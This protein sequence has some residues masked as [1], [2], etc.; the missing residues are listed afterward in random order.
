V[1]HI[2]VNIK[3]QIAKLPLPFWL[4]FYIFLILLVVPT[5]AYLGSFGKAAPGTL[6]TTINQKS[7][8]NDPNPSYTSVFTVQFNEAIDENTFTDSDI[9]LGGTAPGQV[10]QSITEAGTFNKT[11]YEVRIQ[12]TS[13]GTITPTI[14]QELIS[15]QNGASGT[16]QASTS[17]D[18][19]VT[20]SGEWAP[21]EFVTTWKTDNPGVSGSNQI[22][23][24]TTGGGYN[25][26][27]DWGD[28]NTS[29]GL[30]GNS[31]HTYAST[32]TYTVSITGTFPRIAFNNNGDRQKILT[33]EQWGGNPWVS[34]YTAFEGATNLAIPATDAPNL[35]GVTDMGWMLKEA[36]SFNSSINHWNTQNV[37]QI[38][39]LFSGATAFNQPLDSWDVS[40]V[41]YMNAVFS[42][43]TSFNQPLDNWDVSNV[44]SSMSSMFSG[45]TAFNQPLNNWELSTSGSLT[46]ESM[47][48][49]A[50]AFNQPLDS[51]DVSNV[52]DTS[53]MFYGATA[54]NQP[55]DNWDV[56]N[57]GTLSGMFYGA[58]SF[59]Q[60]L[61]SW[62]ISNVSYLNGM[63]GDGS[64]LS[65]ANYDMTLISWN[66]Q[67]LQNNVSFGA[68]SSKYCVSATERQSII[69]NHSWTISDGGADCASTRAPQVDTNS[70]TNI[71]DVSA[72]L[73]GV[74]SPDTI[75]ARG[76]QYGTTTSYGSTATDSS[77]TIT[78]HGSSGTGDGQF[79]FAYGITTDSSG[80]VYVA[81]SQNHRIQKF[82]ADGNYLMR[83]G[84]NGSGNGQMS[85]PDDVFVDSSGNIFVADSGNHRIQKFNSSGTYMSQWG[86]NGSG[87]GQFSTP[88]S[89]TMDTNGD[90][91]VADQDNH[92]I[93]KFDSNGNYLM[94]LGTSGSG[95]GQLN[96]PHGVTV[97]ST[98]YIY[99]A[100]TFNHRIQK[101]DSSGSYV[102]KWGSA[103]SGNGQFSHPSNTAIDKDGNIYVMDFFNHRVQKFSNN[104]FYISQFGS[105]GSG[106]TQFTFPHDLEFSPNGSLY[107]Q[108]NLNWRMKKYEGLTT[109]SIT[110]LTCGT[111]YHY[112]A[113]ASNSFG[114]GYGQ[115]QTFTTS[116]CPFI[117]TWK[118]DNPGGSGS[119]QLTI[120]TI[121]GG[122]NYNVDCGNN[123]SIEHTNQT[124]SV[125]CTFGSPG[126]YQVAITGTFPRIYFAG[127]GDREKIL[128]IDQWGSNQWSSMERAFD[129]AINLTIPAADAPNLNNVTIMSYMFKDAT[130][131]NQPLNSWDMG[132]V[133]STSAM[134][135]GATS[136]NQP[137]NS[138]DVSNVTH[139][140]IMFKD[141]TSFN[142]PLNN[143]D[144]SNVVSTPGMFEGATSFN[145]PLN[146]WDV[147]S[148]EDTQSM[149]SSSNF[150][151]PL[152]NWDVSSVEDMKFL[153]YDNPVFNQPLNDW[154]TA[155]LKTTILTFGGASAFNQPLNN[156][157]MDEVVSTVGM[158]AGAISYDQSL[159]DW[160]VSSVTMMD[161]MFS[162]WGGYFPNISGLSMTNYDATITGWSAQTLQNGVT[163]D[164]GTSMYCS[165]EAQR[166]SIITNFSWT[167]NDA[168][169][170]CAFIMSVKTDNFG[171]S[172]NDS[173]AIP[174]YSGETYNYNVDCGNNGSI[175]H[176]NQTGS[177]TCTFGSPGTYQV[178]I[179]GTFPRI[180]FAGGGD[181]EK[182]LSIDQW[183]SNQWSSMER[184]F[185]GAINLTVPATNAPDLSNVL[186]MDFMFAD[187]TSLNQSLNNWDVSNVT[188]MQRMF[189]NAT[190]FNQPLNNWNVSNVV[191]IGGMFYYANSFNQSLSNWDVSNV[192]DTSWMFYGAHDFNQSL[193]SWNTGNVVTMSRMFGVASAF[194]QPLNSWNVSSVI[195]MSHMFA[196]ASLFDQPLNNWDV[197]SVENMENM[198]GW[199]LVTS[200]GGAIVHTVFNRDISSWNVSNVTNMS[201]MFLANSE[202]NQSLDNWNVSSVIDMSLMF[203][204][205]TSFNQPI[206]NWDVSNVLTMEGM[207]ANT[208][209][210]YPLNNW[211]VS[212]VTNMTGIF[213]GTINFDQSLA[214]W[215]VS[216]VVSM[217]GM[218]GNLAKTSIKMNEEYFG[219][220]FE[221]WP[222]LDKD[223]FADWML[224]T[225][226]ID[227]YNDN[228]DDYDVAFS[229]ANYDAT[230][231]GWSSQNLES[232]VRLDAVDIHYC[233]SE[234]QRQSTIT[235]LS[236]TINDAGKECPATAPTIPITPSVTEVTITSMKFNWQPPSSDGGSPIT[237]YQ[238]QYKASSSST[239]ISAPLQGPSPTTHVLTNLLSGTS[240]DLRVLATNTI[241]SSS[242]TNPITGTTMTEPILPDEPPPPDPDPPVYP[243]DNPDPDSDPETPTTDTETNTPVPGTPVYVSPT[244]GNQNNSRPKST[245]EKILSMLGF[246]QGSSMVKSIVSMAEYTPKPVAQ[247]VPYSLLSLLIAISAFYIY[248]SYLE[249]QRRKALTTLFTR[250][251][252]LLA[253][254]ATYLRITSHYI[255]TPITKMQ[256]TIELLASGITS[257]SSSTSTG[258]TKANPTNTNSS[259]TTTNPKAG[260]TISPSSNSNTANSTPTNSTNSSSTNLP[261]PVALATTTTT[262]TIPE[263]AIV[264]ANNGLKNLANHASELLTEGQSLTGQ[265]QANIHNLEKKK[266]LSFLTHPAFWLPV[267]TISTIVILLNI[268]FIQ[269][270]RYAPT[271]ITIFSQLMLGFVG[272]LALGV[273]Y[274]FYQ[275]RKEQ[276]K[277]TKQQQ[278]IETEFNL[279]QANFIAEA[280][281]KLNDDILVLE[282]VKKDIARYPKVSGFTD[283]LK[284]LKAIANQLEKLA[285]LSKN[286]PGL[287]WNTNLNQTI[288]TATQNIQPLADKQNVTITSNNLKS[289]TQVAVEEQALV[290]LIT[291]PIKNAI[292]ASQPGNQ[293][294]LTQTTNPKDKQHPIQLTITDQGQ[295]IPADQL[296]NIFTPFN[297]AHSL[298][299]F[300]DTGLGIDLYLCKV[301]TTQYNATIDITSQ[302]GE[303]T[304]VALGFSDV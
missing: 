82:D 259:S 34:M 86:T 179:T 28:G 98:G 66:Q 83:F 166:Q 107:I 190:S 154:N 115:D 10:V 64:G 37:L 278:D 248:L 198:F 227:I 294:K 163:F 285:S 216:N 256:G 252:A 51:W 197:S 274:Y 20:Y 282:G 40:N 203:A 74:T 245:K 288:A 297:S 234:I 206:N 157:D 247:A 217:Q 286:V 193:N 268:I 204:H 53:L 146:S 119:N 110:G 161:A 105:G 116:G 36:T 304:T 298:E 7:G 299:R 183:G 187:A 94:Q 251:K 184:A 92:R 264:V 169:K 192:T 218:F 287:T 120:P 295:G 212:N 214:S 17:S 211:D 191:D 91:F 220:P 44:T 284:D 231:I 35:I 29:A 25:Y 233:N 62:N 290:H 150:N 267:V 65:T 260:E 130:S 222:Q 77:A 272:A 75:T 117:T 241:G 109:A 172:P 230:L 84:S 182:I 265:Q 159:A 131:L 59:D 71:A 173:F 89:I 151:Q 246:S 46:M 275:Q 156:W 114:T 301:I 96:Q 78:T 132:G 149:F 55:L 213:N 139:M 167:M 202:F 244:R 127:G 24:P 50:T 43:A 99:V 47:F 45:A 80:N 255:S 293:I 165:A 63:F 19:S 292:Q 128:S 300:T 81:D 9:T 243:P 250:F 237:S 277:L 4:S 42:G 249:T 38:N 138:W 12:A 170:G 85:A 266:G 257:T 279:R 152:N 253:S 199:N 31:T 177:V 133:V 79:G 118:T 32:G 236:W 121:G 3:K 281:N 90:I 73:N 58:T 209:F 215:D 5:L 221:D 49:G 289:T 162:D 72:I 160:D 240:Y 232:N 97:D 276:T 69:T 271:A 254:R 104:G 303:G 123:G 210:N 258:S 224:D 22:T 30:T 67:S 70:A 178:A 196:D 145:Q 188:S 126:T 15:A 280:S 302:E 124:G 6:T 261:P 113:Y 2:G 168:G 93:Q 103:G 226:G 147:S 16:N 87:N 148:L 181:R 141:A 135:E 76:F 189:S 186:S 180:Y 111:T 235:N 8:T 52:Y 23:I 270:S 122:Y 134:F 262:L 171:S 229:T 68:G 54:F 195:D 88:S 269:A 129:G 61:S 21:G 176:T 39:A 158:F 102:A 174:T 185:D 106:L 228:L 140:N 57:V 200:P 11:T 263:N 144:M 242:Y 136:F 142:Q 225:F 95:N 27:V 108:D 41:T 33:V 14:G 26:N 155:N 273:S 60:P 48:S 1:K 153:F 207:L 238:V 239:W 205:A 291:A 112:R 175:E 201:R 219:M 101:F 18:G 164:A 194:N 143:W 100:D 13:T 56:S 208:A 283:G 223:I 125:T 296:A 137:L